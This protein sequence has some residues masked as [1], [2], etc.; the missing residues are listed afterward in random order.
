VNLIGEHTDHNEGFVM[1]MAIDLSTWLAVAPRD[2]RRVIMRSEN[3]AET[4]EFDLDEPVS[5]GRGHWS[6]YSRGVALM[7]ERAGYHCRGAEMLVHSEV[8]IGSGLSSSAAIEVATG[9]ALLDTSGVVVI[10]LELAKICQQAENDYVGM[11]CGLMDQFISCFGRTGHAIMLDCRSLEYKL[12]PL[13]NVVK[14]VLC[15]TMVRHDLASSA[16]NARRADCEAG[17]SLLAAVLPQVRS[18]ATSPLQS[19]SR[20]T[21][22]PEAITDAAGT[23]SQKMRASS[24]RQPLSRSELVTFGERC[25]SLTAA[26]VMITKS[27]ARS[28]TDA[29]SG[30]AG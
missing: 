8:P 1:P 18:C 27:V 23:S 25:A 10:P 17:V 5:H 16:Y 13:P 22:L 15:N 28:S 24:K 14:V 11:R 12:L 3:F 4:V 19:L 6:D 9:F 2:D 20:I 29:G 7:I 30:R 21:E 26:C